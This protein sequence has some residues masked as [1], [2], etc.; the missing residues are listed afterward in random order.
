MTR[1]FLKYQRGGY[2]LHLRG[3]FHDRGQ[4]KIRRFVVV[5]DVTVIRAGRSA[6]FF[7]V[8]LEHKKPIKTTRANRITL[9]VILYYSDTSEYGVVGR[10]VK[11]VVIYKH[12]DIYVRT[13]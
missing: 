6:L 7:V 8:L 13:G 11:C 4:D 9:R 12:N 5:Y 1:F 10:R 3:F 2:D